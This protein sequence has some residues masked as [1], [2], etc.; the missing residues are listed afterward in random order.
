MPVA[1]HGKWAC[2]SWV[3]PLTTVEFTVISRFNLHCK[4]SYCGG[5]HGWSFEQTGC[6]RELHEDHFYVMWLV[7]K[8]DGV[9]RCGLAVL[10]EYFCEALKCEDL[11]LVTGSLM[12]WTLEKSARNGLCNPCHDFSLCWD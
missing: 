1:A 4:S 6:L 9:T 11:Q 2:E 8:K 3:T 5:D 12:L 7:M 10:Y